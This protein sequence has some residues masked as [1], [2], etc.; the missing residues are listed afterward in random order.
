MGLGNTCEYN[1]DFEL[2]DE[3][4]GQSISYSYDCETQVFKFTVPENDYFLVADIGF[5]S[6]DPSLQC[7]GIIGFDASSSAETVNLFESQNP[8]GGGPDTGGPDTGGPDTGGP[9][10]GGP[11]TGGDNKCPE[12]I[13]EN[14]F[15][16]YIG[17]SDAG[18]LNIDLNEFF[19]DQDEDELTYQV[20]FYGNPENLAVP[21]LDGSLLSLQFSGSIGNGFVEIMVSDGQCENYAGF[22]VRIADQAAE[23]CPPLIQNQIQI[24][25][26]PFETQLWFPIEFLFDSSQT[27]PLSFELTAVGDSSIV[28]VSLGEEDGYKVIYFDLPKDGEEGLSSEIEV[29]VTTSDGGCGEKYI[30]GIESI[31]D[32]AFYDQLSNGVGPDGGGSDGGGPDGGGPDGGGPDGGGPDD[33]CRGN[34]PYPGDEGWCG[35]D[36]PIIFSE[37]Y[38]FNDIETNDS[39]TI[40]ISDPIIGGANYIKAVFSEDHCVAQISSFSNENKTVTLGFSGAVGSTVVVLEIRNDDT[41]LDCPAVIA[42]FVDVNQEQG[43]G[44]GPGGTDVP[45]VD[46][47]DP[48][49]GEGEN[50]GASLM[51]TCEWNEFLSEMIV[52]PSATSLS[53]D[54]SNEIA[55]LN[56]P[57]GYATQIEIFTDG[58]TLS[59]SGSINEAGVWTL[60][61]PGQELWAHVDFMFYEPN[62]TNCYDTI[63]FDVIVANGDFG[64]GDVGIPGGNVSVDPIDNGNTG[65]NTTSG[66][67]GEA[68]F[69]GDEGFCSADTDVIPLDD[70][71]S[72]TSENTV[73]TQIDHPLLNEPGVSIAAVYTDDSSIATINNFFPQNN[74]VILGLTGKSGGVA[75]V[76]EI[77]RAGDVAPE[78]CAAV[79]YFI[80]GVIDPAEIECEI[81]QSFDPIFVIPGTQTAE[82]DLNPFFEA[83]GGFEAYSQSFKLDIVDPF[84]TV[85]QA[86]LNGATLSFDFSGNEGFDM[87]IFQNSDLNGN[88]INLLEVPVI[89]D[90]EA[91]SLN[92]DAGGIGG[93]DQGPDSSGCDITVDFG[94]GENTIYF[95]PGVSPVSVPLS[96]AFSQLGVDLSDV[97]IEAYIQGEVGPAPGPWEIDTNGSFNIEVP[98]GD[99]LIIIDLYIKNASGECLGVIIFDI[100]AFDTSADCIVTNAAPEEVNQTIWFSPGETFT[101]DLTDVFFSTQG[102]LLTYYVEFSN[103]LINAENLGDGNIEFFVG[104]QSGEG[105]LTITVIDEIADCTTEVTLPFLVDPNPPEGQGPPPDFSCPQYIEDIMPLYATNNDPRE[106]LLDLN[107]FFYVP[108]TGINYTLITPPEWGSDQD[109]D[110]EFTEKFVEVNLENSFLRINTDNRSGQ[111]LFQ[112]QYESGASSTASCS[113]NLIDIMINVDDELAFIEEQLQENCGDNF[114]YFTLGGDFAG[115]TLELGVQ[116]DIKIELRDYLIN[117]NAE[118]DFYVR[119]DLMFPEPPVSSGGGLNSEPNMNIPLVDGFVSGKSELIVFAPKFEAGVGEIPFEVFDLETGCNYNASILI[120]VVDNLGI[121]DI[122]C[123]ESIMEFAEFTISQDQPLELNLGDFFAV[124]GDTSSTGSFFYEF[125]SDRPEKVQLELNES[126]NVLTITPVIGPDSLGDVFIFIKAGDS[127]EYCETFADIMVRILPSGVTENECPFVY[128]EYLN[129][130]FQFPI[131]EESAIVILEEWITDDGGPGTLDW[132]V[133]MDNNPQLDYSLNDDGILTLYLKEFIPGDVTFFVDAIDSF[134]CLTIEEF[135]VRLGEPSAEFTFNRCPELNEAGMNALYTSLSSQGVVDGVIPSSVAFISVPLSGVYT[136]L[137]GDTIMYDA[138]SHDP[139]IASV[140]LVSNT[141]TIFFLPEKYG[142]VQFEFFARDGDPFCDPGQT[143]SITRTPPVNIAPVVV[144]P[145]IISQI[146]PIEVVQGHP[147]DVIP[148]SQLFLDV[149]TSSFDFYTVSG[150][151]GLVE[152]EIDGDKL[153]LEYTSTSDGSTNVTVVSSN[154]S[155]TCDAELSF[156]VTVVPPAVNLS[157]VF[158]PQNVTVLENDAEEASAAIAKFASH[159]IVS[160]PEG[161]NISLLISAG[162][163]DALFEL[164]PT[165]SAA[166]RVDAGY[167]LFVIGKLDYEEKTF[168]ELELTASDGEKTTS[169]LF[170]VNVGD[171]QNAS[172]NADFTLTVFDQPNESETASG[173]TGRI[174]KNQSY[175]RFTNPRFKSQMEVGKWKVRK[176]ITGGADADLFEI[177][178]EEETGG[179]EAR[180]SVNMIDVLDFRTPPDFE[181]PQ[182]HNKDNVYEVI[183]ELINEDDG[184]SEI[185]VIVNQREISVPENDAKTVEIQSIGASPAQDTDLDGI[186]D[187]IDNSPL[188]PNANQADAD[189]DGVGDVTDDDDQDG[190]WNP[191][192]GCANTTLGDRVDIYG[193]AIFYLPTNNFSITK[194]EKC[195]G[196]NTISIASARADLDYTVTVSGAISQTTSFSGSTYDIENLSAGTYSVCLTVDGVASSVYQRCYSMTITEPQPLS[197]FSI[198]DPGN[199]SVTFNLDG[200][201]IY[202]VTHNGITTQTK[203]STYTVSLKS[204]MNTIDINTGIGCQGEF[205]T[206]YFNSSPVDLAPNPF[207]SSVKLYVGGDDEALSV[208]VFNMVGNQVLTMDKVLEFGSRTI[209]VNTT[210]LMSG[211]Y[212]I[213]INGAT[214]QQT[215]VAIKQ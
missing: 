163:P 106:F 169:Y 40:T 93:G 110:G 48:S 206:T 162:N 26:A 28:G 25:I 2:V 181:N 53:R 123:P 50:T 27:G 171:I 88:C 52:E 49:T 119:Y 70:V 187:V 182:D 62:T 57:D 145:E 209:E 4:A 211:T 130:P 111:A 159:I 125:G 73:T 164:R 24:P 39:R 142:N 168:H 128:S 58:V 69:P 179:P 160:D 61:L 5:N 75:I 86:F 100:G 112:I 117:P 85:G 8:D 60:D 9:D 103:D 35:A 3:Y 34:A 99:Y 192:D 29:M 183:V 135:V 116:D 105:S 177:N 200:G 132:N 51:D 170:R 121:A 46:P 56:L 139:S 153:I 81:T 174:Q 210:S 143:L 109:G 44:G 71:I 66:S 165:A 129:E 161:E 21:S 173:T 107:N 178:Q 175:K 19:T 37:N 16:P 138:F 190:V 202:N 43:G 199:N 72:T 15:P 30:I 157:P 191:N 11:D 189:G 176:K 76:F 167:D 91:A 149:N 98:Q 68:P 67:L 126:D 23:G 197:V 144:C 102:N 140:D 65:N 114:D 204:G 14:G 203:E 42:F 74:S 133:Y 136:D 205:G 215:F 64:G 59:G 55:A 104:D 214:T 12:L 115:V 193:C 13:S 172:I 83:F 195:I 148:L 196:T 54:L 127:E 36:T 154:V 150:N 146:P 63:H 122:D 6:S 166:G 155:G 45:I 131:N 188:Y 141:L 113:I 207:R 84:L 80:L 108:P 79:M 96:S 198:T 95:E 152:S 41:S 201:M 89:V 7:V 101:E 18:S 213:K 156:T 134:G 87:L 38:S 124:T 118:V 20:A 94:V 151:S 90:P 47:V 186:A 77:R 97:Q 92:S 147:L 78:N 208:S 180:G 212:L 194:S 158:E 17:S 33:G 82:I 32:Q 184:E 185:P 120:E 10:T 137:D 1:I 22:E 31:F